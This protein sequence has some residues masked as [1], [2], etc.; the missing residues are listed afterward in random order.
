[1]VGLIG[2]ALVLGAVFGA[3]IGGPAA[4]RF[5][6]KGR[7]QPHALG[8]GRRG[9]FSFALSRVRPTDFSLTIALRRLLHGRWRD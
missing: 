8:L 1:M 4:D 7:C 2:S 9:R 6:R 5:G 3:V